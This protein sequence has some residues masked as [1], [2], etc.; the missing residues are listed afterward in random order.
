MAISCHRGVVWLQEILSYIHFL[1]GFQPPDGVPLLHTAEPG[2]EELAGYI[3]QVA[4]QPEAGSATAR[5]ALAC[6]QYATTDQGKVRCLTCM[7]T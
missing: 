6:L 7:C 2:G 5:A 1:Q 4:E 3:C